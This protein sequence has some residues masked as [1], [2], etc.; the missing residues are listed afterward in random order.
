MKV[1]TKDEVNVNFDDIKDMIEDG[2]VFIHPTDTIYGI[3]CDAT[4]KEAVKK[5]RDIKKSKQPFSVIAPSKDW[6][7]EIILYM[8][9]L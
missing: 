4:N 2:A 8:V 1:M 3:G 9:Y 6:I 7:Y 5:A